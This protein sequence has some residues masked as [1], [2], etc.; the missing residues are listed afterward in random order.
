VA[1]LVDA[2]ALNWLI[3]GSDARAKNYSLLH[4]AGGSTR[5]A[6]L[7]DVASLLP[8]PQFNAHKTRLAMTLGGEYRLKYIGRKNWEAL[9]REVRLKPAEVVARVAALAQELPGQA[10]E[11]SR[12]VRREGLKHRI[13]ARLEEAI[14]KR[15]RECAKL[16]SA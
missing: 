12:R 15:A 16:L 5:L 11:V 3:A 7:Y 9:A 10:E 8:Y 13:V 1:T 2:I 4:G 14:A 6:P